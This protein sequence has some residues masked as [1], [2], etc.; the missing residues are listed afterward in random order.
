MEMEVDQMM[1]RLLVEM[2]AKQ[3]KMDAN[4]EKNVWLQTK[5]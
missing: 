3:E 1:E 5:I 2:R 4:Q